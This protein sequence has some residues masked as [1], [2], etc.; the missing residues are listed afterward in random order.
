MSYKGGDRA[1]FGIIDNFDKDK[2]YPEKYEPDRYG[3]IAICDDALNDWFH[4][5]S[6]TNTYC[7]TYSRPWKG[8]DRYG[9]TL[10][11]PE[12]LSSL[13]EI[14]LTKTKSE[15]M[16]DALEIVNLL[17]EAKANEKFVIHYGI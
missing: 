1:E 12:S 13:I 8:F 5:F 14:M 6:E 10:I 9:V 17:K 15:F 7:Q 3:C 4:P 16:N 2:Y 11:P